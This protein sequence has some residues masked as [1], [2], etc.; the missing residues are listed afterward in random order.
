M[1]NQRRSLSMPTNGDQSQTK[2]SETTEPIKDKPGIYFIFLS[3][4]RKDADELAERLKKDLED[5]GYK[6]WLD[7]NQTRAGKDW[8][9][10]IEE[11]IEKS[12][13]FISLL[14]P[15]AVRRP[16][17]VCLD[18]I[19][20]AR[21]NSKRIIPLMVIPC[22][23]P[24]CIFRLDWIDFQECNTE[25][26]Y[27]KAL[28]RLINE[29]NRNEQ[30]VEGTCASIFGKLEPIDFGTRVADL[31]RNFTG[32]EWL[33]KELDNWLKNDESRVFFV[34]GDPGIG[35]SAVMAHLVEKHAMV[36]AYHFCMFH[37]DEST[38]PGVFIKSISA[39]LATQFE[40]YRHILQAMGDLDDVVK[41]DANSLFK[42]LITDPLSK[43]KQPEDPILIVV[44]AL[45]E[46]LKVKGTN[47]SR[48]L[49]NRL[50]DLPKWVRLVISSR[51]EASI[52]DTFSEFKPFLMTGH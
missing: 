20:M 7:K 50:N 31:T 41:Q 45:D 13:A 10:E 38:D 21:F 29:I 48:L 6:V 18:E 32:R 5:R 51:K 42:R 16:D 46:S 15:H 3:Y 14:T 33:I 36:G 17:G 27:Q 11:A 52:I 25:A 1:T 30:N 12:N 35:K 26:G 49:R 22:K 40:D 2:Q 8:Q 43:I 19:S 24:L 39:Q 34:T 37:T 23:P 9:Y 47:I 4:G 44:D 28:D